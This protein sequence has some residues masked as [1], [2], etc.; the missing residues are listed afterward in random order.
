[1]KLSLPGNALRCQL[2]NGLYFDLTCQLNV[3]KGAASFD[4]PFMPQNNTLYTTPLAYPSIHAIAITD[5][6]QRITLLHMTTAEK[7]N[8][9]LGDIK[10]VVRSLGPKPSTVCWAF[11]F[12]TPSAKRGRALSTAVQSI[13]FTRHTRQTKP[14]KNQK[15]KT[16]PPLVTHIDVGWAVV[17]ERDEAFQAVIVRAI[18]LGHRTCA[19]T[20]PKQASLSESIRDGY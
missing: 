5:Q 17:K 14:R 10:K 6:G 9:D 7:H 16:A 3:P 2:L 12:V 4:A 20:T 13:R 11:I 18:P 19:K 8:V 1:M 15:K